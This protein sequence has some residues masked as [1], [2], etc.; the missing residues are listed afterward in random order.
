MGKVIAHVGAFDIENYGDLLFTDVVKGQLEKR[1]NIDEIYYFAPNECIMPNTDRKVYSLRDLEKMHKAY[2]FNAIILGGGDFIHLRKV[3]MKF[4]HLSKDWELYDVLYMWIIPSFVANRYD[5]PLIWNSPGVPIPFSENDSNI[6]NILCDS[7]DYISVRDP[8]A[9]AVLKDALGKHIVKVVP[10]SVLS[11]K[12]V[13]TKE[14]LFT[15]F[16]NLDMNVESKKYV[17]FQGNSSITDTDLK[18]IAD[19][20][21]RI[22]D[23]SGLDIILQTIGYALGD[24]EALE[25]IFNYYPDDFILCT[26]HTQFEILSLIAHA[27]LYIGTSLHGSITSNAYDEYSNG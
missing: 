2:N 26:H 10:D 19:T 15:V 4:P 20:L 8:E 22:K 9:K 23:E 3:M 1:L 17:F 13:Y 14:D 11:I 7:A 21:K 6:V 25:K 12:D 5:I 24:Y 27:A 18:V 16:D